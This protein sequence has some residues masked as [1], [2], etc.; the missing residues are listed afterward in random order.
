MAAPTFVSAGA[1]ADDLTGAASFTPTMPTHLADDILFVA[2]W[3]SGGDT[4][5]TAT[6]GWNSIATVLG[7]MDAAWFWKRATAPG[8]AGPTITASNTDCFGIG[9]VIRGCITSG[10]PYEAATTA[11]DGT[12]QDSTPDSA[13]ITTLGRDRLVLCSVAHDG[14]SAGVTWSSGNPPALWAIANNTDSADGTD[15]GFYVISR[16]IVLPALV[17]AV[18]VGTMSAPTLVATLTLAFIPETQNTKIN[19][20]QFA[21]SSSGN[22]GIISLGERIK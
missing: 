15:V 14:E 5:V 17:P 12:T 11:G 1:V 10:T 21:K 9:Y 22:T 18:V 3:S 6:G 2:A 8:T 20:Y 16:S 19:N 13:A 4:P 7:T